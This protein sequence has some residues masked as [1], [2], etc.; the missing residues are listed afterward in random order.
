MARRIVALKKRARARGIPAIYVNDNFARWK[1]DFK[2]VVDRCLS[3][4][5]PGTPVRRVV[6]TRSRRLL[7]A[8]TQALRFLWNLSLD[9]TRVSSGQN[10]HLNWGCRQQLCP[11]VAFLRIDIRRKGSC[12]TCVRPW[13]SWGPP[14]EI[15]L[16]LSRS[17]GCSHLATALLAPT[18]G[19]RTGFHLRIVIELFTYLTTAAAHICA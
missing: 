9:P 18:T 13:F 14:T 16:G 12:S 17:L 3:A 15:I 1:S 8:E 19:L 2:T 10:P 7:C 4:E 5:A 11:S 6:A